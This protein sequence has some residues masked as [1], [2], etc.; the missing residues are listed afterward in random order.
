MDSAGPRVESLLDHG[1]DMGRVRVALVVAL[2]LM[3]IVIGVTLTRSPPSVAGSDFTPLIGSFT[4]LNGGARAC[5]THEAL[6][7]GASAV[8]VSLYAG[9]GPRVTVK[10]LSGGRVLTSGVRGAGWRGESPTVPLRPVRQGASNVTL[11]FALG[12]TA[13]AVYLDGVGSSASDAVTSEGGQPLGGRMRIDYLKP[14]SRSWLSLAPSVA[15]RAG[16]GH[17]PSGTWVTL[18]AVML[19]AA[20]VAG[21]LW[22]LVSELR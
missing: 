22:L 18:F 19:I 6:P 16:L 3:T 12:Q 5:Q 13:E 14:G 2:T 15:R 11:C 9:L 17:W 4:Q 1:A 7:Q 21:A 8:R 10:V 20:V